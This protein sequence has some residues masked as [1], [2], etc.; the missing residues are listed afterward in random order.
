MLKDRLLCHSQHCERCVKQTTMSVLS[1]STHDDQKSHIIVTENS[2]EKN[3]CTPTKESFRRSLE[4]VEMELDWM[5]L[6]KLEW[7]HWKFHRNILAP[8]YQCTL[9]RGQ[10]FSHLGILRMLELL[11]KC[12][13]WALLS[14]LV[15]I[16]IRKHAF[17]SNPMLL[18][19]CF[20]LFP[21]TELS[22]HVICICYICA[23]MY[24]YY[25]I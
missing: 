20:R 6:N 22:M 23:C 9:H 14:C 21:P 15:I 17:R 24:T 18:H 4:F 3:S 5:K 19:V 8:L 13:A 12:V 16:I 25:Y 1:N 11:K 2:R 10:M 7:F